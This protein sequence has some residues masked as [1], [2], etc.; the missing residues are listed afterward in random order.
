[1]NEKAEFER[2]RDELVKD[3][4][5]Q[6][7]LL[8]EYGTLRK[9]IEQGLSATFSIERY[10]ILGVFGVWA[11]LLLHTDKI[12]GVVSY[13]AW[14]LPIPL[15]F[16]GALKSI[17]LFAHVNIVGNYIQER[18]EIKL[19]LGW[20]QYFKQ[21]FGPVAV[22]SIVFWIFLLV[23]TIAAAVTV[24]KYAPEPTNNS[25]QQKQTNTKAGSKE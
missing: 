8:A 19:G 25:I 2:K 10:V 21:H 12:T 13:L 16:F 17:G 9:E 14:C 18:L 5:E 24:A 4:M 6:K 22:I 11:W 7:A 15:V 1:M 23:A 3:E 20:Q